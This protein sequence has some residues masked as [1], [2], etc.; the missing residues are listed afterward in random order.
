MA[1]RSLEERIQRLEEINE[2]QKKENERLKAVYEI[3]NVMGRYEYLHMAEM[4]D[5]TAE[6]FA[7]K[8]PGV[9]AEMVFGVFEGA[10]GIKRLY[11]PTHRF[12]EG[13]GDRT[14]QMHIHTLTT[15]VIEVAGDGKT[16]K[17]VWF[18][19]GVETGRN[20]ET[21]QLEASWGW[22]RYG[23]DFI[24]EDGKWKIWHLHVYGIFF[25]PYDKSWIEAP[26]HPNMDFL[27]D[28][29]KA[30]RPPTYNW[31]YKPTGFT[32]LVPAPPEPYE[33]WDESTSYIK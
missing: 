30:D 33:T 25:A 14:G 12:M 32:E 31:E 16:A 15:P 28:K 11:G 10:A 29:L 7:L 13:M 6:L 21:K 3:Q 20:V 2:A 26:Q 27:P 17:A 4:H 22:C 24:K 19:P 1:K 5:E 23:C 8:T 9:K 18:S